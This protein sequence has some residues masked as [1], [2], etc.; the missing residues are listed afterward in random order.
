MGFLIGR[1]GSFDLSFLL[2][3]YEQK[4]TSSLLFPLN[5]P[6]VNPLLNAADESISRARLEAGIETFK[7][8]IKGQVRRRD[9]YAFAISAF[10]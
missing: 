7:Q 5:P 10:A 1:G 9:C 4:P 8:V 3:V 2:R 6:S